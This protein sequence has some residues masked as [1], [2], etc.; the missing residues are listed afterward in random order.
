MRACLSKARVAQRNRLLS[1]GQLLLK[2]VA[3]FQAEQEGQPERF[4][5]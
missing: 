5:F 4:R 2:N 1:S 3:L